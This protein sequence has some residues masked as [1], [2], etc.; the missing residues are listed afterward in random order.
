[1]HLPRSSFP[2][3]W[4]LYKI[5]QGL[6]F[7]EVIDRTVGNLSLSDLIWNAWRELLFACKVIAG[8]G[9]WIVYAH[10]SA[11]EI[12]VLLAMDF[13][14]TR[15]TFVLES[16]MQSFRDSFNCLYLFVTLI[17]GNA[18]HFLEAQSKVFVEDAMRPWLAAI[19]PRACILI[20]IF[21]H[22]LFCLLVLS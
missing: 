13:S 18:F 14:S 16:I 8:I 7:S 2:M 17:L 3:V 9:S 19:L 6:S 1:M 15:M 5:R 11:L 12:D 22:H 21:V 4:N 20:A 10:L